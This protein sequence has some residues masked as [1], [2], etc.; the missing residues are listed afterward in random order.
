MDLCGFAVN[1][2]DETFEFSNLILVNFIGNLIDGEMRPHFMLALGVGSEPA[3]HSGMGFGRHAHIDNVVFLES[4]MISEEE[5]DA[6][7][8][9]R[10][11]HNLGTGFEFSELVYQSHR[12]SKVVRG[13]GAPK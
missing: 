3:S 10:H 5:I 7:E 9:V 11:E 2:P 12:V 13:D 8:V 1:I 4:W 6:S